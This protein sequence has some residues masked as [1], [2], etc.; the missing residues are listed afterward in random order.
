MP[1]PA[2]DPSR[3]LSLSLPAPAGSGPS[4]AMQAPSE[5]D[6]PPKGSA[7]FE[8][9]HELMRGLLVVE[10]PPGWRLVPRRPGAPG[11]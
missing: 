2:R 1:L 6:V 10:E 9:S 3:P 11:A 5:G 4:A 7:W 8:S